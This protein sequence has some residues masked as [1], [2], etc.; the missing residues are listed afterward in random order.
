[1]S[2]AR[3]VLI[4]G[5][6]IACG[7]A[8]SRAHAQWA[9]L[10]AAPNGQALMTARPA[11]THHTETAGDIVDVFAIESGSRQVLLREIN[12]TTGLAD[13]WVQLGGVVDAN[14]GEP[15]A[16]SWPGRREVFVLG[17]DHKLYRNFS[18]NG[19]AWNGWQFIGPSNNV[20]LC[21]SP[22]AVS[23][24]PGR[25]DVLV[26]SCS[27]SHLWMATGLSNGWNWADRGCCTDTTP[28]ATSWAGARL[29]IWVAQW[30]GANAVFQQYD[31]RYDGSSWSKQLGSYSINGY[32]WA[33]TPNPATGS[34]R[35]TFG[36]MEVRPTS[37]YP[38]EIQGSTDYIPYY[39]GF[40][41]T[42]LYR[43]YVVNDFSVGPVIRP[44]V[45]NEDGFANFYYRNPSN[46]ISRLTY[47]WM[48]NPTPYSWGVWST[49]SQRLT[50]AQTFISEA[51]PVALNGPLQNRPIM[52]F[53][54]G[55][56]GHLF[57]GKDTAQ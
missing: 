31:F 47:N 28:F 43:P 34:P 9:D 53:A 14:N 41:G 2:K 29:D 36:F 22:S 10:G 48:Q 4:L 8:S 52:V 42:E 18:M 19:G 32:V 33:A 37:D 1:M 20:T 15:T 38:Q 57:L 26:K 44:G 54:V 55:S 17:T 16:V 12:A 49:P 35:H 40:T 11:V 45:A 5:V 13:P 23:W 21:S 25:I 7:A 30:D 24:G 56:N 39:G 46:Q 50:T 51:S 6:T 27:D 3:A